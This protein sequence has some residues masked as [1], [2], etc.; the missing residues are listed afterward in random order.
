MSYQENSY[1][2]EFIERNG[3]TAGLPLFDNA[4]VYLP[5]WI[6]SG[7]GLKAE[8]YAR[9]HLKFSDDAREYL[10][11]LILLGGRGTDHE[12]KDELGWALHIVSARRNDLKKLGIVQSYEGNKKPGPYGQPNTI[13]YVNFK[14]LYTKINEV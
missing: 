2:R 10:R 8:V 4:S 9:M 11:A 5:D 14:N 12:V 13:W 1:K 6:W 3:Q 7:T